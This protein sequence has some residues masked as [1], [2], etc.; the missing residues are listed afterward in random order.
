MARGE[1][2]SDDAAARLALRPAA[3]GGTHGLH[4]TGAKMEP[5]SALR[6]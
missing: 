6:A 5:N 1:A 4:E 3:R 2:T